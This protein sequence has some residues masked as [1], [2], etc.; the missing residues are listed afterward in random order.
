MPD[1]E[2]SDPKNNLFMI[3]RRQFTRIGSGALFSLPFLTACSKPQPQSNSNVPEPAMPADARGFITKLPTGVE[4]HIPPMGITDGSLDLTLYDAFN[5][6]DGT[7]SS[8][9]WLYKAPNFGNIKKVMVMVTNETNLYTQYYSLIGNPICDPRDVDIKLWFDVRQ[10][11]T[12][13]KADT[14]LPPDVHI[15]SPGMLQM[16]INERL[17]RKRTKHPYRPWKYEHEGNRYGEQHF[18]IGVLDIS[19][20]NCPQGAHWV[21]RDFD[22]Y[23]IWIFGPDIDHA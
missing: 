19:S 18:R 15:S 23:Q 13:K 22:H 2:K 1:K 16:D 4:E 9:R 20:G 6:I 11:S 7:E 14:S 3:S 8:G 5:P 21:T 17:T 12:Y 10:G